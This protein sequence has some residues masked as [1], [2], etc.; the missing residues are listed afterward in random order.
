VTRSSRTREVHSAVLLTREE[1]RRR[2]H[3]DAGYLD[4]RRHE[5][6]ERARVELD[7]NAL[8]LR[9]AALLHA[10][11]RLPRRVPNPRRQ[12]EIAYE[13]ALLTEASRGL[14]T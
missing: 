8:N 1:R 13:R 5:R 11:H 12:W 10:I 14:L 9:L 4:L 7:R 6:E 2:H 3:G